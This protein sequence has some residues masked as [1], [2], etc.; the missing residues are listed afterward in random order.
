MNCVTVLCLRT[1]R[2]TAHCYGTS[3]FIGRAYGII[4]G[5]QVIHF[6]DMNRDTF[7]IYPRKSAIGKAKSNIPGALLSS[8]IMVPLQ[9]ESGALF[10]KN[11]NSIVTL[12]NKRLPRMIQ[13]DRL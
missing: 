8:D 1:L 12:L 9:F 6:V 13:S 4:V 3:G 11:R 2:S 5:R 10:L 7:P